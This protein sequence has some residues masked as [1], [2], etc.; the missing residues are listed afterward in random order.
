MR[1]WKMESAISV[2]RDEEIK[3]LFLDVVKVMATLRRKDGCPWDA[4][5]TPATLKRFV[6]E[7]AYEVIETIEKKDWEGL[8]EE[9]GDYLLQVLFQS[10]I[11][12]EKGRYDI[13]DVLRDLRDKLI[14]RHPHVFSDV[15][16][17]ENLNV[18]A[19]WEKIKQKEKGTERHFDGFSM[20]LPALLASYKIGKKAEKVGFDW[21]GPERVMEKVDEELA[22]VKE[23]LKAGDQ[24][25]LREELG[26]LLFVVA[27]LVRQCGWDPEET[28]R[29]GNKKFI[30]RFQAMEEL[31]EL[32][33]CR[34]EDLN[35]E[36][37]EKLWQEVKTM[38]GVEPTV[39]PTP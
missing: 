36:E 5:Q 12:H 31:A 28:L 39:T 7:E 33:N 21:D 13:G 3:D 34:F 19:Q 8:K 1:N 2:L 11:Q 18:K 30:A 6:L 32:R 24:Q 9:L 4:A 22:E 15:P 20:R 25:H 26:D 14:R 29:N 23:A 35:L 17:V 16:P 38:G 27:N 37:Q 10:E